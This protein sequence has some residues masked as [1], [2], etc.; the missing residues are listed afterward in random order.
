MRF[1]WG[2][3]YWNARKSFFRWG[4][5]R[6]RCPCQNP[7]DSGRALETA[8]D[9]AQDW[10]APARFRRVCPLLVDTPAGFRCSVDTRDVR[11]FWGR[12]AACCLGAA[13][14]CGLAGALAVFA[15]LRLVGYPISP[16]AVI[17][18]ARWQELRLARSEYFVAKARRALDAQRVGEAIL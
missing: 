5:N 2:L 17:W 10:S 12:A 4:G 11:P 14:G 16:L 1:W 8:C 15:V 7:S 3:F 18:P 13:V 9:A 6:A